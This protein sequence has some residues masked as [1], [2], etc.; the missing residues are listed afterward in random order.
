M[1]F[2]FHPQGGSTASS[3][4]GRTPGLG[5]GLPVQQT[6]ERLERRAPV[7][8]TW[9]RSSEPFVVAAVQQNDRLDQVSEKCR[10]RKLEL[11]CCF[12][13]GS[14]GRRFSVA[15]RIVSHHTQQL[16]HVLYHW[17]LLQLIN[18]RLQRD[19]G[20]ACFHYTLVTLFIY[21]RPQLE[22]SRE[23][24]AVSEQLLVS[25][26][27]SLWKA[28]VSSWFG[29]LVFDTRWRRAHHVLPAIFS[30]L[31]TDSTAPHLAKI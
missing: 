9:S 14:L 30:I 31:N 1:Q 18:L 28:T 4:G 12:G 13:P 11:A 15:L 23:G 19:G 20:A 22:A 27:L 8:Q 29:K 21:F 6:R 26:Y 25:F 17:K 16:G 3:A 7:L 2:F 5:P 24:R 10:Y